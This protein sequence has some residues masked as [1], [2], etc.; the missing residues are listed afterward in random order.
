MR[1][2][3]RFLALAIVGWAGVRVATLGMVAR[4]RAV[5]H[6]TAARRPQPPAIVPTQFP[7][8][9]PIAPASRHA[10]AAAGRVPS[11][12]HRELCRRSPRRGRSSCRSITA[13]RAQ[14][15]P[16]I[17]LRAATSPILPEPRPNFYSPRAAARRMAAVAASPPRRCPRARSRRSRRCR[18]R[19]PAIAAPARPH[20]ADHVGDAARPPRRDRCTD[21]LASGGTLGG[22]Q[23]GARLFYNFS[24]T[25][26]GRSALQLRRRPARRRGRRRGSAYQPLR[27]IAACGSPPSGAR[28]SADTA[29]GA[30][31]S[32]CSPRAG[33]YDRPMPWD[34]TLDGYVQAGR[35]R[36]A[37]AATCSPTAAS[38]FTR[39]VYRRNSP[40]A[41]GCG[42]AFSPASIGSMPARGSP[43]GSAA[44]SR[45]ISTSGSACRATPRPARARRVTL[46]GDF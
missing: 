9:D 45:S 30:T 16:P 32:L 44:T 10:A 6:R 17:R 29:A 20:P 24:P 41:S 22:S 14:P 4:R 15:P 7:P 21:S 42:A 39:P 38:T 5:P 34:F 27:G 12:C 33:V 40:P 3:L 18:L 11:T 23:A 31:I 35:R 8:I 46:A 43:C 25:L 26:G 2:S 37:A 1:P 13:T 28:R 19:R 36:P